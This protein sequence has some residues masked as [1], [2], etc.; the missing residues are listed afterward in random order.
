MSKRGPTKRRARQQAVWHERVR[1]QAQSGQSI[2]E[3]CRRE[4]ITAASFYMWR[5]RH[6]RRAEAALGQAAAAVRL[7]ASFIDVGTMVERP[8]AA[9]AIPGTPVGRIELRIDLGG[10]MV[11]QLVRQ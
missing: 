10:G 5:G 1:R 9:D 7:P 6:R 2:A 3:F 4:G 8:G 11:L